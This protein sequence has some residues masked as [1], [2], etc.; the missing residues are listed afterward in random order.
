[1]G[2]YLAAVE[3]VWLD[4]R[5]GDSARVD[6]G[7]VLGG[8]DWRKPV[9]VVLMRLVFLR[10]SL[11]GRADSSSM[12]VNKVAARRIIFADSVNRHCQNLD[13]TF[14]IHVRSLRLIKIVLRLCYRSSLYPRPQ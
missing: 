11:G 5:R 13:A 8:Y 12:L 4:W 14:H 7:L 3:F 6:T 2:F 1:M 10:G 9:E